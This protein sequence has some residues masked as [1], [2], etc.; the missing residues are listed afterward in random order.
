MSEQGK[1]NDKRIYDC[2]RPKTKPE[3]N[4]SENN[5]EVS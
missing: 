3:K 4:I 2:L 1:E 5:F